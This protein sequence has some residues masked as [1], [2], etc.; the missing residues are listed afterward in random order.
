MTIDAE[1]DGMTTAPEARA[2]APAQAEEANE[3]PVVAAVETLG[4]AE[5]PPVP[6]GT[7]AGPDPVV[8]VPDDEPGAGALDPVDAAPEGPVDDLGGGEPT[9]RWLGE[10]GPE[11]DQLLAEGEASHDE[12]MLALVEAC[13][14]GE[15][16]G[17]TIAQ[18][19]CRGNVDDPR[20]SLLLLLLAQDAPITAELVLS[21]CRSQGWGELVDQAAIVREELRRAGDAGVEAVTATVATFVPAQGGV[22]PGGAP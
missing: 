6:A 4:E 16:T 10:D 22:S 9:L 18:I 20:V 15:V 1:S 13:L 5:L 7:V 2:E 21:A 17:Q 12:V 3:V 19:F 8:L 11:V 14:E